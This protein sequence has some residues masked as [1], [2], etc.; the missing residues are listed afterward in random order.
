MGEGFWLVSGLWM[1]DGEPA[2]MWIR[3]YL[4]PVT[5]NMSCFVPR[6]IE[7]VAQLAY[8]GELVQTLEGIEAALSI[9]TYTQEW[10]L[11]RGELTKSSFTFDQ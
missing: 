11:E 8:E 10:L 7:D 1:V 6:V 5:G 9:E 3:E 2:S 4:D